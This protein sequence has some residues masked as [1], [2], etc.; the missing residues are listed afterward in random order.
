MSGPGTPQNLLATEPQRTHPLT[1]V[2]SVDR[3]AVGAIG[4]AIVLGDVI[5]D[6]FGGIGF[7]AAAVLVAVVGLGATALS[8]W[9]TTYWFDEAGDLRIASGMLWRNERRVQLSRLQ[10]V[11]VVQPLV[12]R[13][14]GLAEVRPEMAGG[15]GSS[16]PLRFLTVGDARVFRAELLARAAGVRGADPSAPAPEAPERQLLTVP[17]GDL[18]LSSILDIGLVIATVISVGAVVAAAVT[19][20][21]SL[22]VGILFG[23]VALTAGSVGRFLTYYGFTMAESPDGLRLR[24]GLLTTQSQTVPPGR[25]Q[26]IS[27]EQPLLWRRKGWVRLQVN[28]A[29]TA[30][31][32]GTAPVLLPVAPLPV[33]Q[34]VLHRVIPG[35][36]LAAL[37]QAGPQPKARW[38]APL[39]HRSLTVAVDDAV[40]AAGSGWLTRRLAIVPHARTQSVRVTQGPVQ[41]RLGLADVHVDSTPGSVRPV[42]RHRGQTEARLL[43]EQ[44]ADRAGAARAAARPERWMAPPAAP[45][46]GAPT[47]VR[48]ED[49]IA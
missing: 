4:A 16:R 5:G 2:A 12:A 39:Q 41:R 38:R 37:P 18:V 15:E 3:I 36:D 44:Q 13:L 22:L 25:V 47:V 23:G 40:F 10:S 30:G 1:P 19:Q 26:A 42:A 20:E 46:D 7:A 33:A 43:A 31:E 35:L 45:P 27:L 17:S 21:I 8:W 14:I 32:Q 49:G 29:G 34:G 28:L 9:F 11:E 6:L 24:H 48:N